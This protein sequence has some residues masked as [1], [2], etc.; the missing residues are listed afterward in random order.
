MNA[1]FAQDA[2]QPAAPK[3]R[4]NTLAASIYQAYEQI[5]SVLPNLLALIVVVLVGYL[6]ARVVGRL[7]VAVCEKVGLQNAAERSGLVTS[8]KQVGIQRSVPSI[9]GLMFFWMLMCVFLMAGFN[10]LGWE[11]VSSGMGKIVEYIP[12]LLVGTVVVVIGLLLASFL[13]GVVATSADRAG[14]SY[15]Q[16]LATG[17]YWILTLMI[18]MAAFD[19]LEIKFEL[20]NYAILI[21]FGAVAVGLGLSFGLGGREVVGG[22]L[23]GYYVRQRMQ[24]GDNVQIAGLEGTV[25][26][27]GPVATI[28]ETD[29]NGL[30]HRHSV[31]NTRMLNEA[32]R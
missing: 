7:A 31:P 22:I 9:V 32:I 13:R 28:I 29:E 30:V 1:L 21:A 5:I 24:S 16:Q 27:V 25:R 23:A 12:K 14:L 17:C 3:D 10:I 2:T 6:V 8:M 19:Q 20:F 15:A 11:G 18:F 26:D 4:C